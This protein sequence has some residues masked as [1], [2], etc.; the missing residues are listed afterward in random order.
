M[1]TAAH[2]VELSQRLARVEVKL[3]QA[4][5]TLTNLPADRADDSDRVTA[6][7]EQFE[8]CSD[9]RSQLRRACGVPP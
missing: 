9:L 3:A 1:T 5:R 7:V 2:R 4:W 6:L 8:L